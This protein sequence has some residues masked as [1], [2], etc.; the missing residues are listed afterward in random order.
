LLPEADGAAYDGVCR[1]FET[2]HI[3]GAVRQLAPILSVA[4]IRARLTSRPDEEHWAGRQ[5]SV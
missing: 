2:S 1:V 5:S 4:A 3:I